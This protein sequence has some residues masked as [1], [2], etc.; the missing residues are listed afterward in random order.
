MKRLLFSTIL[1]LLL[2]YP[3]AVQSQGI[4][5]DILCGLQQHRTPAA[6]VAMQWTSN[7]L[8]AVPAI[9]A[10]LLL[11][12]LC[13]DDEQLRNAGIATG[14]SVITATIVTEGLKFSIR[15]PRPYL[16]YPDDLVPVKTTYGF[17]FPS[18]HTSLTFAVATSLSLCYPKWYVVAPSMLWATSVAF[19]RLYLG[20]HYPSDVLTGMLVGAASAFAGYYISR[21]F[22]KE[23]NLP[24]T[25]VMTAPIVIVF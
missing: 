4:D 22:Q 23:A 18:G 20:V 15:R 8:A 25:K 12:G 1:S 7:T 2:V 9:P 19:S 3:V 10:G 16:G 6:N 24:K 5:Y 17:S 13:T 14:I 21:C 11:T